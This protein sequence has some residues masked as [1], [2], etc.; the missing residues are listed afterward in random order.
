MDPA[1]VMNIPEA[2][3]TDIQTEF[4]RQLNQ[5]GTTTSLDVKEAL[6][7]SFWVNQRDVS[8]VLNEY[9]KNSSEEVE[10][11]LAPA[12]YRVYK[13]VAVP[14]VSSV[15]SATQCLPS[16]TYPTPVT[17]DWEVHAVYSLRGSITVMS[18]KLYRSTT[19]NKARYAYARE[20]SVPY[21][22]TA[23]RRV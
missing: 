19:R 13:K 7:K 8:R 23:A 4:L 22:D 21:V 3:E 18:P 11:D 15:L 1:N 2:T 14:T 17:G 6:R 10:W 12:G 20:F 16:S 5:N 9:A